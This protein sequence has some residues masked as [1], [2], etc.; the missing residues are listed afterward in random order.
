MFT[1]D[2]SV[3]VNVA[4]GT[5]PEV[6]LGGYIKPKEV[7][8]TFQPPTADFY[9]TP[10]SPKAG[11]TVTFDGADS[12]DFD[13]QVVSYAWDFDGDGEVDVTGVTTQTSFPSPGSYDVTLTI[14]D[15]DGNTDAITYT[16]Y[17]N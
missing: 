4:V 9:F 5:P 3:A 13:G 1:T 16:V 2:D 14:T 12:F 17:V 6:Q 11:E 15:N 7:V 8:I 10:E